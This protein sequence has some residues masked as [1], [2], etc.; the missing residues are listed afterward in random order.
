MDHGLHKAENGREKPDDG[1]KKQFDK[2]MTKGQC[3][4]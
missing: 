1:I 2:K 3:V 4:L